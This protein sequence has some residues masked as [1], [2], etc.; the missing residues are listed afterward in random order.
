MPVIAVNEARAERAFN[1]RFGAGQ[2]VLDGIVRATNL[3]LA[4]QTI[5][6]LGYGWTG[7][8]V[9]LRAAG[10]GASVIVCEVDPLRALEARMEGFAVMPALE[11]AARRGHLHHRH[12][13][14][15]RA[16]RRA[17][18]PHEGRRG[19]GQRGAVRRRDLAGRSARRS[20]RRCAQVLPLVERFE[21][22][23]RSLHLVAGGRVV[24]LAAAEGHPAAVM[25][26][27]FALQALAAEALVR[28]AV[29]AGR[30]SGAGRDRARGRGV[31]AG[32]A[33]RRDR[34]A[35]R[36][37]GAVPLAHIATAR[38]LTR[39]C[40]AVGRDLD[41]RAGSGGPCRRPGGS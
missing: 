22:G 21:F 29:G 39:I 24:N 41:R 18:L 7:R 32:R 37:P 19:A 8:G 6:V 16:A 31:E 11:A 33:G 35:D 14:A 10:F 26:V 36:R 12:G 15:R 20:P 25:D 9:A 2:S 3:L 17:L 4:G 38:P 27:S 40:V 13:R 28:G 23:D 5:V 30:A 34:S 1:D